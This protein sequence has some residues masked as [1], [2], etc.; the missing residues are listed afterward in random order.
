MTSDPAGSPNPFEF[1]DDPARPTS[2]AAPNPFGIEPGP[3]PGRSRAGRWA[4]VV[5]LAATLLAG[6]FGYARGAAYADGFDVDSGV[7]WVALTVLCGAALLAA[8]VFAVITVA[9]STPGARLLPV[10]A[11]LCA[12]VLPWI[13][14][15]IGGAL[16]PEPPL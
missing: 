2:S 14:V 10:L 11:L 1:D 16:A 15:A 5:A 12:L 6:G 13:A 7:R 8:V 9:R 4:L 3:P